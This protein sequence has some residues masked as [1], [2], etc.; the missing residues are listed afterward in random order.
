MSKRLPAT[1][2]S[3][4]IFQQ[5]PPTPPAQPAP[6]APESTPAKPMRSQLRRLTAE[7]TVDQWLAIDDEATKRRRARGTGHLAH[8]EIVREAIAL[9]I[10]F[11]HQDNG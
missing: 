1:E 9:W 6:A 4:A 8:S 3:A 5:E 2:P 11:R 7:I 10:A